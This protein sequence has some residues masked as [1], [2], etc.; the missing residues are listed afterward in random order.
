MILILAKRDTLDQRPLRTDEARSTST[1]LK[2]DVGCT[3]SNPSFLRRVLG[4]ALWLSILAA[5]AASAFAQ[6]PGTNYDESKVPEYVLPDPLVLENGR[7][8]TDAAT[9]RRQRRP[10][11]LALFEE[12]VYGRVPGPPPYVR[13]E[14]TDVE[15]SVFGGAASRKQVSIFFAEVGDRPRLDLLIYLPSGHDGPVPAFLALNFFGNQSIYPDAGIHLSDQWMM[16]AGGMGIENHKATEASRGVRTNRWPVETILDRGYA[17]VTGYYGDL[18][19]DYD[20]G[21]QNG[22]HSLFSGD[23]RAQRDPNASGAIGAWAWGLSRAL[24]YL[25]TDSSVDARRVALLGHSRLGKAA[26]WAGAADDRFALVISNNSGSGGAA[27]SRRRFGE[28]VENINTAFPHW[29]SDA[30][31]RYNGKEHELPVD[32]HMLIALIAPR[33]VYIAS[34]SEDLWADPR[35][36]FLS[37]FHASPVYELLGAGGIAATEQ[38]RLGATLTSTIGYH[39]RPGVHDVTFYDW[40][41]YLDFA[42]LHLG[43]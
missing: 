38:P 41:R 19:P 28:T 33:P 42:D 18:D 11:V 43:E 8:V 20:D 4:V 12:H 17:L 10:E 35:G 27:L 1:L 21:F 7:P 32:Q 6:R 30:Y 34:A 22:V 13:Y 5:A 40:E 23:D 26:L 14:V 37:G 39:I 36:E 9:W 2:L 24:D 16:D 3:A 29:F 31:K 25:E 15:G